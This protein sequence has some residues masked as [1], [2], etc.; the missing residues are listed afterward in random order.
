M[1]PYTAYLL[2][3]ICQEIGFPKGV[4]NIVHGYGHKVGAAIS[5]HPDTPVISF[6]GRLQLLERKLLK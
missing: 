2:S 5:S 6:T 3:E 1:T 4:L